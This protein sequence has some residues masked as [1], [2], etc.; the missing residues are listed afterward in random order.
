MTALKA[1]TKRKFS[2][3]TTG[4]L[5]YFMLALGAVIAITAPFLHI[6]FAKE[7]EVEVFGFYNARMFFYAIGLPLTLFIASLFLSF[8]SNF[9]KVPFLAKT[10][11]NI[12]LL[13]LAIAMYYICWTLWA[14]G[15]FNEIFYY[16]SLIVI[17]SLSSVFF[18]RLL[19]YSST[20]L[21]KLSNI[22]EDVQDIE[23]QTKTINDIANIMSSNDKTVSFK[24][25]IDVTGDNLNDSIDSIN[26]ELNETH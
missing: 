15:D 12:S 1:L 4:K 25:M 10:I 18:D 2:I 3:Q 9:I 22:S 17:A 8:T 6:L 14:K 23:R 26:Q 20:S 5:T 21:V 19:R 7:S 16:I 24:A 11:K 13:F